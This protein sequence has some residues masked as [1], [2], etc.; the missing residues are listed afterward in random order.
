MTRDAKVPSLQPAHDDAPPE[1][2]EIIKS[3]KYELDLVRRLHGAG[4][5]PEGSSLNKHRRATEDNKDQY[6]NPGTQLDAGSNISQ[7]SRPATFDQEHQTIASSLVLGNEHLAP[8]DSMAER[9]PAQTDEDADNFQNQITTKDSMAS[10]RKS[11][12]STH[13]RDD[14][15]G[16]QQTTTKYPNAPWR[17][18]NPPEFERPTRKAPSAPPPPPPMQEAMMGS[19]THGD[20]QPVASSNQWKHPTPPPP[21]KNSETKGESTEVKRLLVPRLQGAKKP[22][23]Y[24]SGRTSWATKQWGDRPSKKASWHDDQ[25]KTAKKARETGKVHKERWHGWNE[26]TDVQSRPFWPSPK[27]STSLLRAPTHEDEQLFEESKQWKHPTPPAPPKK[28]QTKRDSPE[29]TRLLVP[30]LKRKKTSDSSVSAAACSQP[31]KRRNPDPPPAPQRENKSSSSVSAAAWSQPPKR[32]NP[33]PPPPPR[34]WSSNDWNDETPS[35]RRALAILQAKR[36]MQ[37]NFS[38]VA[39]EHQ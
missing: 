3:F 16:S 23:P 19:E 6:Q 31:P 7:A 32:R 37:V 17:R 36:L 11:E 2:Q 10:R 25:S 38:R 35:T 34:A 4:V 1:Q 12:Q 22:K 28:S 8:E 9:Y 27:T 33:V 21:L 24:V 26:G 14:G 30:R 20:E 15:S 39:K 18:E 29:K 13:A 5:I